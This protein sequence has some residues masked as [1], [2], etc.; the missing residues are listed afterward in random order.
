MSLTSVGC[1]ETGG[2]CRC[3]EGLGCVSVDTV[4][5][6]PIDLVGRE[7]ELCGCWCDCECGM[8]EK[9]GDEYLCWVL[10]CAENSR[11]KYVLKAAGLVQV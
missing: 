9:K 7:G 2:V 11:Y 4:R 8:I 10:T 3:L 5:P 1:K 6:I